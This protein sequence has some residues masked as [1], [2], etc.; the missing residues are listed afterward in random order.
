MKKQSSGDEIHKQQKNE[1][2]EASNSNKEA[3]RQSEERELLDSCEK[4]DFQQFLKLVQKRRE[5]LVHGEKIVTEKQLNALHLA[6]SG[7]MN[8]HSS[9]A[10][11]IVKLFHYDFDC[12]AKGECL[13][14]SSSVLK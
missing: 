2:K 13:S 12:N 5:L 3:E 6:C 8:G 4:G 14:P 10:Q 11:Y 1:E 7:I 9:I